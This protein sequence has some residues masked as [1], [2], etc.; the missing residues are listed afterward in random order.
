MNIIIQSITAILITFALCLPC[1]AIDKSGVSPNTI[2]LPKGPG[3]IEGLGESFQPTLNTGTAKY[4]VPIKLPQA[5]YVPELSLYYNAGFGNSPFG[6]GWHI[7]VPYVQRQT[8]KGIPQYSTITPDTFI[9][10]SKEELIPQPDGYYF[11][12]IEDEFIRYKK[13][14]I[15]WEATLPD[16]VKLIFGQSPQARVTDQTTGNIFKWMLEK[17]IDTSG[18][19]IT[20]SYC[21]FDDE[22]N[23]NQVYLSKIQYNAG[24]PPWDVFH[25]AFFE[26]E[27]RNDWFENCRSGFM[28]RTGKRLKN[29]T[30]G[31]Q[32][33]ALDNHISGDFN[34]DNIPDYLNRRYQITYSD[35]NPFSLLKKITLWGAD[36]KTQFPPIC[37]QYTAA[38]L[39]PVMSANSSVIGSIN[40]PIHVMD[41]DLVDLID[42]NADGLPD[43][44]KTDQ[45]GG[46]H[47]AFLNKGEVQDGGNR[48]I[49]WDDARYFA[50][51]PLAQHIHLQNQ[52]DAIAHLADM[53]GDGLADLVYTTI[54]G[55]YFFSNSGRIAWRERQQM[56]SVSGHFPPSPFSGHHIKTADL[57]FDKRIDIIQSISVGNGTDYRIWLNQGNNQYANQVTVSQQDG[58]MLSDTGVHISDFN[59][60]RIPDIVRI[61]STGIEVT[62]GLGY[63]N[64][65]PKQHVWL[66]N[67]TLSDDQIS[68]ARLQDISGDGLPDLVIER[69]EAN[70]LWYWINLGNY[71]L[72]IKRI[73]TDMPTIYGTNPCIRWADMNGNGTTDFVYADHY[74]SPKLQ[75]VDIGERMGCVPASNMLVAIDN[76]IGKKIHIAY[77]TSASYAISDAA[78]NKTWTDPLPS[79]VHVVSR[80]VIH[81]TLGHTSETVFVYHNGYYDIIDHEF[82]G[83]ESIEQIEKGDAAAPTLVTTLIFNTGRQIEAMKGKILCKTLSEPGNPVYFQKEKTTWSD[84]VQLMSG[85]NDR[86]IVFVHPVSTTLD[87]KEQGRGVP[88]TIY[89]EYEYDPYGNQTQIREYGITEDDDKDCYKDERLTFTQYAYNLSDWLVRYPQSSEIRDMDH[90]I[91][92]TYTYYDD[93]SFS[94]NNLGKLKTGL[95]TLV[96]K[97]VN[98]NKMIQAE[99][100][101]YNS[102]GKPVLL[103]DPLGDPNNPAKGHCRELEYD[104]WFHHFPISE[105]I[106]V[107]DNKPPLKVQAT[108]DYGFSLL[109]SSKDFN[110]NMTTY[111]YDPFSRL[112]KIIKP[113]NTQELP[114]VKYTY[115]L[116]QS[117]GESSLINYVE[118]SLLDESPGT[119]GYFKTRN[120]F[121][122][123]GRLLMTKEE[124]GSSEFVVKKA[125]CFNARQEKYTAIHPYFSQSFDFEDITASDWKGTFL[126]NGERRQL[127]YENAHKNT[128]F[129]DANLRPVKIV[130]SDKSIHKKSYEPFITKVY[131]ENDS[132]NQSAFFNTPTIIHYDGLERICQLDEKVHMNNDGTLSDHIHTWTTRYQYRADDAL[133]QLTDSVGNHKT[134]AYDNLKRKI[135]MSD[136][137]K[138]VM[139]YTYDDASNLIQ[140]TDAKNQMI[141][142][143]YDGANRLLTE[144][145]HDTFNHT[146]DVSYYYDQCVE[147]I[148]FGDNHKGTSENMRGML[149]YVTDLSGKEYF[150]YDNRGRIH[151]HVKQIPDPHNGQLVSYKTQMAYD[152]MDRMTEL[153]YPDN[154][155]CTFTYNT[156]NLLYRISGGRHHHVNGNQHIID[157]LKYAPSSQ[158]TGIQYGNNTTATYE[159]DLRSRLSRLE[160]KS[161]SKPEQNILEYTYQYDSASNITGIIDKLTATQS[162][163]HIHNT[164]DFVYDDLYRLINIRYTPE[165]HSDQSLHDNGYISYQY[166]PIGNMIKKESD[167]DHQEK[168]KS[169]TNL[170]TMQYG[171]NNAGPHALSFADNGDDQRSFL[172]DANGNMIQND[173]LTCSWDF[174]NRLVYVENE[175]MKAIYTYDYSDR[176]ISKSVFKK[177]N[178][179]VSEKSFL[180]TI[181]VNQYFEIR[182]G[183]Q[184]IK[185][186]YNATRRVARIIGSLDEYSKRI[187]RFRLFKGWNF[188]SIAVD[189]DKNQ[190]LA[191]VIMKNSLIAVYKWDPHEN[192]YQWFDQTAP[193]KKGFVL[194]LNAETETVFSIMGNYVEPDDF[195]EINPNHQLINP[196]ALM[197]I[198][199]TVENPVKNVWLFSNQM[200]TWQK[201]L[202]SSPVFVS[203]LPE[204]IETGQPIHFFTKN[205]F[206][207]E[208]PQN[209][210][211]IQYYHHDHLG[212]SN[213]ITDGNGNITDKTVFYPFGH[214]RASKRSE[215]TNALLSTKY[216]F[217]GKEK[218]KETG[219][220]YFEARYYDGVLGRFLSV[221]PMF[222]EIDRFEKTEL[223]NLLMD[224]HQLNLYSYVSNKPIMFF[225][226]DGRN[227]SKIK[228]IKDIIK[229]V[230]KQFEFAN[231][232]SA[233]FIDKKAWPGGFLPHNKI[234]SFANNYS[235]QLDK[236]DRPEIKGNDFKK[237]LNKVDS[238]L[239]NLQ[240]KQEQF[241]NITKALNT[242][243][244]TI[245]NDDL[246]VIFMVIEKTTAP[247]IV[248]DRLNMDTT[249][250]TISK[251]LNANKKAIEKF[252]DYQLFLKVMDIIMVD[253]AASKNE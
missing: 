63:G 107:S 185:Y 93:P 94:G 125:V 216:L 91:S 64:F 103:I 25:F 122:G 5:C 48:S 4:Q 209:Y 38:Q 186:V 202:E 128:T 161:L 247:R 79:P 134:I 27:N 18:N 34:K 147:N 84:P 50:G 217:T 110:D 187:Q 81:D 225:D 75:I 193:L 243:E 144:N 6:F 37:F 171:K 87:I 102:Y 188:I 22:H 104:P 58:Y 92:Q 39:S 238:I 173:G 190:T 33:I 136:P 133:T 135:F 168:G 111:H 156:Q 101:L 11:H 3:S 116:A 170:G 36:N 105:T 80:I 210:Q 139:N 98:D 206:M 86:A 15:Y 145:Y 223:N 124:S 97:S 96:K 150:S 158:L 221:D 140:T 53:D 179:K 172:Y 44:L 148:D 232:S 159:Y 126:V 14:G 117:L 62:T 208:L 112:I 66:M 250:G 226:P 76:G 78:Q 201:G 162:K 246:C 146:P 82:R 184:P 60:D 49:E 182:E 163:L 241:E 71:C 31:T 88:K 229:Y 10:N 249:K 119:D 231:S 106:H 237:V 132:D 70:R 236:L 23:T 130:N 180:T 177:I 212:S 41:N 224:S 56:N 89:T 234:I 175:S 59:G 69:A 108:Y 127:N 141:T 251:A 167:I 40:T 120:F 235:K 253:E 100:I 169:I 85:T 203:D 131:D 95:V 12:E 114:T 7:N 181:Y 252:K 245:T 52:S 73:I 51:D 54:D 164:Q 99:R 118:T 207:L 121:D 17:Q 198:P 137:D 178:G 68:K 16:G 151:W 220:Q 239:E 65:T 43:I 222:V 200:Q 32:G 214:V 227:A 160:T 199:A 61:R 174:K 57:D 67:D 24:A 13:V 194:C 35:S 9:D 21:A 157:H 55:V 191:D 197:A 211:R 155:R 176:R 28:I 228:N 204:F 72:D 8:D 219:L 192:K 29:I 205:S 30:I 153:T 142:Y 242:F 183:Y 149:S 115:T 233:V 1:Q 218:D 215:N 47:T 244:K 213:V 19:T 109:V 165:D 45:F 248:I 123:Q 195:I 26:Y 154:D 2:S 166:D 196:A 138:G 129:Y 74:A 77:K 46:Q 189:P 20:Y 42:I 240:K 113:G 90:L 230:D 143:S 152:S 83:F